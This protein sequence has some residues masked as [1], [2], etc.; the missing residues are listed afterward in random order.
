[1]VPNALCNLIMSAHLKGVG[2]PK[3]ANIQRRLKRI[4]RISRDKF[5]GNQVMPSY[6]EKGCIIFD[7]IS[8]KNNI[9]IQHAMNGGEYYI[10]ELGYWLDGYDEINNVAYEFDEKHHFIKGKIREKD[11]NR[12]E[13][14]EK[15]L[16]CKFIRIK[17]S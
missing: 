14:V 16:K 9:H 4:D 3:C 10:K 1:M 12:Q 5:D 2:C 7:N 6:N 15:H 13:E 17:D 8:E 11:I